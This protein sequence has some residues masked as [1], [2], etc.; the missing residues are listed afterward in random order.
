MFVG[1]GIEVYHDCQ[2]TVRERPADTVVHGLAAGLLGVLLLYPVVLAQAWVFVAFLVS[3]HFHR[4]YR[5]TGTVPSIEAGGTRMVVVYGADQVVIGNFVRFV[6]VRT[7]K[8]VL[9]RVLVLC[10]EVVGIVW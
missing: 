9:V 7:Y 5:G 4:T 10:D 8:D 3:H 2:R 1:I 6:V